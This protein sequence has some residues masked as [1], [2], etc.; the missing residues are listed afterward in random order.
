[1]A[2]GV[3]NP[4]GASGVVL[5]PE[6]EATALFARGGF[7]TQRRER[8]NRYIQRWK[9]AGCWTNVAGL[10]LFAAETRDQALLNWAV[11]SGADATLAGSPEPTFTADKGFSSFTSTRIARVPWTPSGLGGSD[12]GIAF[13]GLVDTSIS[14]TSDNAADQRIIMAVNGAEVESGTLLTMT[15]NTFAHRMHTIQT[16]R[17]SDRFSTVVRSAYTMIGETEVGG[18]ISAAGSFSTGS[19]RSPKTT[20]RPGILKRWSG[21]AI[22]KHAMSQAQARAFARI[23]DDLIAETGALD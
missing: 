6:P 17:S 19:I 20:V 3:P 1:M 5:L 14:D 9:Q 7:S 4:G 2:A 8:I 10:W 15:V 21:L 16:Q 18:G 23:W 11:A 13:A 22:L 12:I